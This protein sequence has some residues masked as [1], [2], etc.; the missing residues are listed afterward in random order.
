MSLRVRLLF[1][2]P[3]YQILAVTIILS[4]V[5]VSEIVLSVLGY[6]QKIWGYEMGG[7]I[8][9]GAAA[10]VAGVLGIFAANKKGVGIVRLF[11]IS[12]IL[13]CFLSIPVMVLSAGGLDFNSGFYRNIQGYMKI[14]YSSTKLVHGF[15]LALAVAQFTICLTTTLVCLKHLYWNE[16]VIKRQHA[17]HLRQI[18][19]ENQAN[20]HRARRA[21]T[22]SSAPLVAGNSGENP[23]RRHR[24]HKH[25]TRPRSRSSANCSRGNE[26]VVN[27]ASHGD[28][29]DERRHGQSHR[30]ENG[31]DAPNFHAITS[32][33][34]P[35]ISDASRIPEVGS[36]LMSVNSAEILSHNVRSNGYDSL[37]ACDE[38]ENFQPPL[39]IE[40]DEELPP[41]EATLRPI[42]DESVF[43][44]SISE[45]VSCRSSTISSGD[46]EVQAW[47][48]VSQIQ[49]HKPTSPTHSYLNCA[50][51]TDV[52]YK[53]CP[54]ASVLSDSS[55]LPIGSNVFI[56]S[57]NN[58]KLGNNNDQT[59]SDNKM[60]DPQGVSYHE[61]TR[62][63]DKIMG[64]EKQRTQSFLQERA[65]AKEGAKNASRKSS[66]QDNSDREDDKYNMI[67][68]LDYQEIQKP[69]FLPQT[70]QPPPKPPR[71]GVIESCTMHEILQQKGSDFLQNKYDS[72][73]STSSLSKDIQFIKE[74]PPMQHAP[75]EGKLPETP[76]SPF[77]EVSWHLLKDF[78]SKQ[79]QSELKVAM[80]AKPKAQPVPLGIQNRVVTSELHK[81]KFLGDH[82]QLPDQTVPKECSL[83]NVSES[84]NH[85][86]RQIH[87][88]SRLSHPPKSAKSST[89]LSDKYSKGFLATPNSSTGKENGQSFCLTAVNISNFSPTQTSTMKKDMDNRVRKPKAALTSALGS[90]PIVPLQNKSDS[91]NYKGGKYELNPNPDISRGLSSQNDTQTRDTV[92]QKHADIDNVTNENRNSNNLSMA[93]VSATNTSDLPG[94]SACRKHYRDN[95]EMLDAVMP[96]GTGQVPLDRSDTS[97][98]A[99]GVG[100][101]MSTRP[102]TQQNYTQHKP[103]TTFT[104]QTNSTQPYPLQLS[105]PSQNPYSTGK[106]NKSKQNKTSQ[107]NSTQQKPSQQSNPMQQNPSQ[108][109]PTQQNPSQRSNPMQQNPSRQSNSTQQNP[110]QQSNSTQQNPSHQ[111]NP[112]HQNKPMYSLLL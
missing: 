38:L 35:L 19:E 71:Q 105:I 41:Y 50:Q 103:Q 34:D 33:N 36:N 76:V 111:S 58:K 104:Q 54:T 43:P 30:R 57:E 102:N 64:K 79:S 100:A 24:K 42:D 94:A 73:D 92:L 80:G 63:S 10:F 40:D 31:S 7:G 81:A 23:S 110:S 32:A 98:E 39:P 27:H 44:M 2:F 78:P 21:S 17:R 87:Q 4:L 65:M 59:V 56:N 68:P 77:S 95:C 74:G 86:Q 47:D 107:S 12:S 106:L 29:P 72:N 6:V 108:S 13:S 60:T 1:S 109:N 91:S 3:H 16:W 14:G 51:E 62:D 52:K 97:S 5:G 22:G 84:M 53:Y 55:S 82:K 49:K 99:V 18:K 8:W 26:S 88:L 90:S 67:S 75:S 112:T 9:G 48:S 28:T 69:C 83:S 61:F 96:V 101:Y 20:R 85:R 46:E 70:N 15:L 45:N 66:V 25:R 37:R 11:L 93:N 89:I